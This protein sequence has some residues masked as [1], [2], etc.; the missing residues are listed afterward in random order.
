MDEPSYIAVEIPDLTARQKQQRLNG[1]YYWKGERLPLIL[2]AK[3][4]L[5][6]LSL[7]F[8]KPKIRDSKSY[9]LH[10]NKLILM[11]RKDINSQTQGVW[12]Y[13]K[14]LAENQNQLNITISDVYYNDLEVYY[15]YHISKLGVNMK[16]RLVGLTVNTEDLSEDTEDSSSITKDK[17]F[18][19]G[20]FFGKINF[21]ASVQSV[22]N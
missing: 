8:I 3:E 17:T 6:N 7:S 5:T 12:D 4:Q 1:P 14:S 9:Q 2:S 15:S 18:R 11:K 20:K 13:L 16:R 19:L 22:Y 21:N 10:L